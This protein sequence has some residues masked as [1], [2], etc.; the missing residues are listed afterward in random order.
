MKTNIFFLVTALILLT[1]CSNTEDFKIK[2]E[3]TGPYQ[4][5][6]YLIYTTRTHKAAL[7]DPGWKI[8]TLVSFIKNNGLD[9]RYIFITHGHSD[10]YYY[11]PELKKQFP[12][13]KWCINKEDYDK[14]IMVPQW[15]SKAYGQEWVVRT[16]KNPEES[17]YLDF[18]TRTL[19]A[20]D[21]YVQ[22]NQTF[23]LGRI[24]IKSLHTPG[25]SPGG[26][27]YYT[28]SIL[29]SGD[30]LFYRS[31]GNLDKLTSDREVFI[32]TVR[33]LYRRFPDSTVVYPG[34][35]QNTDIGSEKKENKRISADDGEYERKSLE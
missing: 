15:Q 28:G 9:L 2:R 3:V 30:L 33:D 4:A 31:V 20:P 22:D 29:F 35:G 34:H 5:N 7:V 25:H 1:G 21:I 16:R 17:V 10:H 13:A 24:K 26:M 11:V 32:N 23:K 19:G 18:D 14:V 27:C 8:D 12:E 6:C